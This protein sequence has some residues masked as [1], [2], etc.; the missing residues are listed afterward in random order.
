MKRWLLF[1]VMALALLALVVP[2]AIAQTSTPPATD[3]DCPMW[4]QGGRGGMM[5]GAA[6]MGW[7][8]LPDSALELLGLSAEEVQAQHLEGK[9]LADIAS[10]QG[11]EVANLVDAIVTDRVEALDVL[12]KDG[13]ISQA[14]ADLMADHMKDMVEQMVD[15]D[16]FGPMW[17]DEN[18][19]G[20]GPMMWNDGARGGMRGQGMR[21]GMRGPRMNDDG[22]P[23]RQPG[24]FQGRWF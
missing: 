21:G 19:R 16:D 2:V 23:A 12:V 13:R 6:M 15:R 9:S 4:E 22:A 20:S 10:D 1:G 8:G 18:D 5:G 17:D 7:A 14:Q 11:V 24:D 3:T